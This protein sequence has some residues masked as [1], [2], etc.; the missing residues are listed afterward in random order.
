MNPKKKNKYEKI[1]K[2]E[3]SLGDELISISWHS[4]VLENERVLIFQESIREFLKEIRRDS[5]KDSTKD[6]L[7]ISYLWEKKFLL[8]ER[9]I[10]AFFLNHSISFF[11]KSSLEIKKAFSEMRKIRITEAEINDIELREIILVIDRKW[12]QGKNWRDILQGIGNQSIQEFEKTLKQGLSSGWGYE[13]IARKIREDIAVASVNVEILVR[14]EGARIQNDILLKEYQ[15]NKEFLA[16]IEY[17]ATLDTRTCI[18]C[19][20]RD[21]KQFWYGQQP[22]VSTAP[23]L[24]LHP[25]CRCCYVPISNMWKQLGPGYEKTRASMFGPT[26]GKYSD[27][28][29]RQ[30]GKNPGFA[31]SVLGKGKY[32]EWKQTKNMN[33]GSLYPETNIGKFLKGVE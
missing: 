14:T 33:F 1:F 3:Q 11:Q 5:T 24:P 10:H 32:A 20:F 13:K 12:Q 23:Q 16:G 19:G 18:Y 4:L 2:L 7:R 30:E 9:Y 31:E 27:W 15:R 28:L 8:F 29:L 6:A 21:G 26:T 17:T 22:H 25:R